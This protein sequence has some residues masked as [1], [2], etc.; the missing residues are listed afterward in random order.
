MQG[1]E[2]LPLR[3]DRQC[4]NALTIAKHLQTHPNV[5]W[6]RYPLIDHPQECRKYLSG[7][8]GSIVVFGIKGGKENG[9]KFIDSL[10]LFHHVANVGDAKSLAIHPATTTHSQLTDEQQKEAGAAPELVRLSLGIEH[11]DDLIQD[12]DQA[13]EKSGK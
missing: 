4:E 13:L 7:R 8:G 2:T 1:I 10:G 11:P 6:V 9:R 5:E 12:V 3:V